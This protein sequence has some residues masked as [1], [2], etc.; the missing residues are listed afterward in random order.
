MKHWYASL[1]EIQF[2]KKEPT[3]LSQPLVKHFTRPTQQRAN[4]L[5]LYIASF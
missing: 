4:A 5:A 3:I 2:I 1:K